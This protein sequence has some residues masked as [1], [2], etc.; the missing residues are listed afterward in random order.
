MPVRCYLQIAVGP[1][2]QDRTDLGRNGFQ[3]AVQHHARLP[4][5][6]IKHVYEG[7]HQATKARDVAALGA[8]YAEDATFESASVVVTWPDHGSGV[9]H[10]PGRRHQ[11]LVRG[12]DEFPSRPVAQFRR[13]DGDEPLPPLQFRGQGRGNVP[14]RMHSVLCR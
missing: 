12:E 5:A 6:Q 8:L 14:C 7:W 13:R 11:E 4:E 1:H 2:R 3:K 10:A 9:L